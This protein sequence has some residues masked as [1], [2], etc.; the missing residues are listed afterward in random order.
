VV[1]DVGGG[2]PHQ[3]WVERLVLE[4][5]VLVVHVDVGDVLRQSFVVITRWLVQ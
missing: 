5:G 1:P 4:V 3:C 2:V